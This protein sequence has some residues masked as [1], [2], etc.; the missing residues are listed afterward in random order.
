VDLRGA[1]QRADKEAETVAGLGMKYINVPLS[2][3]KA[4]TNEQI[5]KLFGILENKDSGLVFVHCRRGADRTGTILAL[6]RI[7]HDHWDNQKALREA[8]TM[9]MASW[10]RAMRN[11]VLHYKPSEANSVEVSTVTQAAGT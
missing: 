8:I 2:G 7:Q 5:A 9:K 10:E 1:G 4:P 6:Y 3:T 11:M